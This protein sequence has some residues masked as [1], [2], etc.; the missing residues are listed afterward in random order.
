MAAG[1]DEPAPAC[2]L[3]S[4]DANGAAGGTGANAS[5]GIAAST[6]Q[7]SQARLRPARGGPRP[8]NEQAARWKARAVSQVGVQKRTL[9]QLAHTRVVGAPQAAQSEEGET[10]DDIAAMTAGGQRRTRELVYSACVRCGHYFAQF[11]HK[12]FRARANCAEV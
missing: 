2:A 11:Q 10:A 9:T 6:V 1:A 8:A 7:Y 12:L 4:V 3:G 5:S